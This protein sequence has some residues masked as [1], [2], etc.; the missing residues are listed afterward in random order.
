M[1]SLHRRETPER[2]GLAFAKGSLSTSQTHPNPFRLSN[3]SDLMTMSP[4]SH[5]P[6]PSPPMSDALRSPDDSSQRA[7]VFTTNHQQRLLTLQEQSVPRLNRSPL[8]DRLVDSGP[9]DLIGFVIVNSLL[10]RNRQAPPDPRPPPPYL[11]E[12]RPATTPRR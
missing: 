4:T 11:P 6:R 2:E 1:G 9:T 10:R 3:A 8:V 5:G 12:G 7:R